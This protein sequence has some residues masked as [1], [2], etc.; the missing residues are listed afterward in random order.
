MQ[1]VTAGA[2]PFGEHLDEKL[3]HTITDVEVFN[4]HARKYERNYLEV[5]LGIS[6]VLT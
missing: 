1:V 4:Q 6:E 3:G 2:S 5:R